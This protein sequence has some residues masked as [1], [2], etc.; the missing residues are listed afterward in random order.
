M[1]ILCSKEN[2]DKARKKQILIRKYSST[3]KYSKSVQPR[4]TVTKLPTPR[5][6]GG[7][8]VSTELP[9]GDLTQKHEKKWLILKISALFLSYLN[10][11]KYVIYLSH[12]K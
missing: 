1:K 11:T 9:P 6:G 3:V 5:C 12:N 4:R 2:S 10:P 8:L 7:V